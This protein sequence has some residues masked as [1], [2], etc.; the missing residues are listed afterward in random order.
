[1]ACKG[2]EDFALNE[3]EREYYGFKNACVLLSVS[4]HLTLGRILNL[5]KGLKR[6]VLNLILL[7][8]E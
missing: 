3:Q 6:T 1:M 2:G 8:L 4:T 5:E 7:P